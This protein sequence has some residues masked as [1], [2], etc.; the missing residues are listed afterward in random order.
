MQGIR[1][2]IIKHV[3]GNWHFKNKTYSF[4]DRAQNPDKELTTAAN[5]FS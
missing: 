1:T 4:E 3:A 2:L 5:S